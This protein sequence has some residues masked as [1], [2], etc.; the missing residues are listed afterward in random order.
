MGKHYEALKRGA[1]DEV[2]VEIS[3]PDR[4]AGTIEDQ[5]DENDRPSVPSD[6]VIQL[7]VVQEMP[8]LLAHD[9]SIQTLTERV[10]PMA[11]MDSSIR[12]LVSGCRPG[13]GASTIASALALDLSQRFG[14]RTLLVDGQLRHPG[15]HR[16]ISRRDV[17]TA[18][19][20]LAGLLRI[21][22]TGRPRLELGSFCWAD[23][24]PEYGQSFEL[25]EELIK[26][27]RAMVVDLGVVRLEPRLLPLARVGDPILLVV[28]YGHT[29]RHDLASTTVG[30]R[31]A[32]RSPAGVILNAAADPITD[33]FRRFLKR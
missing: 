19:T 26:D 33:I 24:G 29:E 8:T 14:M 25:F 16:L 15:L 11:A 6:T 27:Y 7:P 2:A 32:G 30:L 20:V 31:A 4:V 21:Q 23:G 28:R 12:I 17:R 10:A 3:P 1:P 5:A 18:D 9:Q 22:A 13:D